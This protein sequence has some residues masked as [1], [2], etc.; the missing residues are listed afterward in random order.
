MS[1]AYVN[2][3][4][5]TKSSYNYSN[6]NTLPLISMP[7]GMAAWSPQTKAEKAGWY[8]HPEDR[9]LFGLR[10]TRQPSPWIRDYGHLLFAPQ[11]GPMSDGRERQ[12]SSFRQD[13]MELRPNY[14]RARLRRYRT[15]IELSPTMRCGAMR[16]T[17][18]ERDRARF[19]VDLIEGHGRLV[20]DT[21]A[22]EVHGY[23][24][25]NSGGASDAF[26]MY[27][28]LKFDAAISTENSAIIDSAGNSLGNKGATGEGLVAYVGFE[29]PSSGI[30]NA[31][32]ASSFI[33]LEQA[34]LNAEREIGAKDLQTI[35]D[36]A[37]SAWQERLDAIV[38]E[39]EDEQQLKTF[40]SCL[41]RTCLFPHTL[42]EIDANGQKIHRNPLD[43]SIKEG[44]MY[45][46]IGF[47][48]VYRTS[49]PLYSLLWPSLYGEMLDAWVSVYR[50]NGWLP[51]WLSPGERSAMP[52]TLIDV[53]MADAYAKG[54]HFDAEGAL[55]GMLKHAFLPSPRD[56]LGRRGL[57]DYKKLGYLPYDLY[58][59][60]IN[61]SLDYVYGDFCISRMAEG[62]NRREEAAGLLERASN[63]RKLFDAEVGFMRAKS[64]QGEWRPDFD[65]FEWGNGYCEGGPWQCS[66][67]VQHDLLGLADL[68]GGRKA[69]SEKLDELFRTP[70]YFRVG[71]YGF[72]IHEMSEMAMVDFGQ[73]A[74]SNQPSFH[75]PYIYTALGEP[76]KTQYWVRKAMRELF[77]SEADGFPGDEDNG[78]LAAWYLF[79]AI[80]LYPLT[81][82]VPEYVLGCP[83]FNR[84]T[85]R[86][87]NGKHVMI[88]AEGDP[89]R[90]YAEQIQ[91]NGMNHENLYLTHEQV[92]DG[93]TMRFKRSDRPVLREYAD[94]QLP[95]SMSRRIK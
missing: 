76:H 68:M 77:S 67:A 69:L 45:S 14:V 50:S 75:I 83:A 15:E 87:D 58:H 31:V 25:A 40:Y 71:S 43:G 4:Q 91:L 94:S 42:H 62:L 61:N 30:V 53:V 86:L 59:E 38:V 52:G 84:I 70:P 64:S 36:E 57:E 37:A 18:H 39:S 89:N 79:G 17:Y 60:S 11:S 32:F 19:M 1:F 2:I 6:G 26:V 46:D 5:G 33:S 16:L 92:V 27:F 23:T 35:R 48:D 66:W 8:Y 51:K 88:E 10:L 65:P 12:S 13:E 74:I 20:V 3:K 93:G 22:G 7:F 24:N 34:R 95:F 49:L 90:V 73:F 80:G 56:G 9:H 28:C 78:S 21:Q 85:L 54:I 72:E 41:Y 47:W 44:P 63:Y 82:G 29:L 55:E 81:P